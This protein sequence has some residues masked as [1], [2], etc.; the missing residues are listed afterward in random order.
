[1]KNIEA[2]DPAKVLVIMLGSCGLWSRLQVEKAK[3]N[4][5]PRCVMNMQFYEQVLE[6]LRSHGVRTKQ[7]RRFMRELE[8]VDATGH[9]SVRSGRSLVARVVQE[10]GRMAGQMAVSQQR[11]GVAGTPV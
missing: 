10:V 2:L 1:M 5:R 6:K 7:L 11:P 9:V 8:Y 3:K 4:Y